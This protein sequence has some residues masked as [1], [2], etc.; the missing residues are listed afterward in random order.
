M[1]LIDN[2]ISNVSG[3]NVYSISGDQ[4]Y[5]ND[6]IKEAYA[7]DTNET[8]GTISLVTSTPTLDDRREAGEPRHYDHARRQQS[9]HTVDYSKEKEC[10]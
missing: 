7:V 10:S 5:K 6:R 4:D 2:V 8:L 9:F 3:T 1:G